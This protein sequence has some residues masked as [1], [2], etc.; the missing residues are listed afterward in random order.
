[1]TQIKKA[2]DKFIRDLMSRKEVVQDFL[3]YYLDQE[4][5]KLLD[6]STL[7]IKKDTFVDQELAEHFS[8]IL[9]QL[10]FRNGQNAQVY[11]LIEHKSYSDSLVAFQLLRYM[12]RIWELELKQH[13]KVR[14]EKRK[15]RKK[16]KLDPKEDWIQA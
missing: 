15:H 4:L 11:V 16:E 1:M 7:E 12:I 2:H 10:K 5:V 8:D 6:L 14:S 9:Y 13:S 3:R